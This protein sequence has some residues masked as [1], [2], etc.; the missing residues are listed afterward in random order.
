MTSAEQGGSAVAASS[1]RAETIP[2]SLD[3]PA[4][5]PIVSTQR[6]EFD[7]TNPHGNKVRW[8][9]GHTSMAKDTR[10]RDVVFGMLASVVGTGLWRE[11]RD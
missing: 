2:F 8:N 4:Q 1:R 10:E 5:Q 7:G 11:K 6:T 3:P 9:E